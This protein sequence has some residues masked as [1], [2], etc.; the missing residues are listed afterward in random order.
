MSPSVPTAPTPCTTP[1]ASTASVAAPPLPTGHFVWSLMDNYEWGYGCSKRFGVVHVGYE[2]QRRMLKDRTLWYPKLVRKL[3]AVSSEDCV[4]H[5]CQVPTLAGATSAR[6]CATASDGP[7][8]SKGLVATGVGAQIC[9]SGT[10][11]SACPA[12]RGLGL[13]RGTVATARRR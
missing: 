9:T 3:N 1:S 10:R 11:T 4:V 13:A 12:H 7:S 5:C 8:L 2:T 6:R